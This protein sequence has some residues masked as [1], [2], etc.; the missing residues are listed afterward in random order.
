MNADKKSGIA[1]AANFVPIQDEQLIS[2]L[3]KEYVANPAQYVYPVNKEA[4]YNNKDFMGKYIK[5]QKALHV[6][7]MVEENKANVDVFV[8][9]KYENTANSCLLE[10]YKG[11]SMVDGNFELRPEALEIKNICFNNETF[12]VEGTSTAVKK[13]QRFKMVSETLWGKQMEL[14]PKLA[15][16]TYLAQIRSILKHGIVGEWLPENPLQFTVPEGKHQRVP[17]PQN[18]QQI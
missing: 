9:I 14:L 15:P 4:W 7:S 6:V 16:G 13:E 12:Q 3:E 5:L 18:Y 11:G 17:S 8:K 2:D 1:V 10:V